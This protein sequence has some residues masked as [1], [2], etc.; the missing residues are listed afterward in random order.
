MTCNDCAHFRET[1]VDGLGLCT[2]MRDYSKL[3]SIVDPE[4]S[5]CPMF[6]VALQMMNQTKTLSGQQSAA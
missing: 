4:L 6:V 1:K 2:Q 3:G 5:A